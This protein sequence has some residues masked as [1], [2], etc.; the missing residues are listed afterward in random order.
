MEVA[1]QAEATIGKSAFK[2][3]R[4]SDHIFQGEFMEFTKD[5]VKRQ[6]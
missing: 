4:I 3:D 5:D 2:P 6:H 1:R